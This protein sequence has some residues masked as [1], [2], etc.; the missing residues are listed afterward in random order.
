M[1]L[2]A[3]FEQSEFAGKQN[4]EFIVFLISEHSK[5]APAIYTCL[6]NITDERLL[7]TPCIVFYFYMY[8]N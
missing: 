6:E 2:E 8:Y 7:Y 5:I 4:F 3:L 1:K